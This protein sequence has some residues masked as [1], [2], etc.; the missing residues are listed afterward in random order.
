[1]NRFRDDSRDEALEEKDLPKI[2]SNE[3]IRE[4]RRVGSGF[5][6]LEDYLE[7]YEEYDE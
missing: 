4:L 1:M 5:K 3:I 6:D 7:E 2:D